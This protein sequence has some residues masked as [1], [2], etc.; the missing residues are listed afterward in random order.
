M[1]CVLV[2]KHHQ[3][4]HRGPTR[5]P[6]TKCCGSNVVSQN[7]CEG[8]RGEEVGRKQGQA[9][10]GESRQGRR[11]GSEE[12]NV[13]HTHDGANLNKICL[14]TFTNGA[15]S[16]NHRHSYNLVMRRCALWLTP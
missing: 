8:E 16:G 14:G 11:R 9:E 4:E 7:A 12:V 10:E 6:R 2:V 5:A 3:H 1:H 13:R 15:S